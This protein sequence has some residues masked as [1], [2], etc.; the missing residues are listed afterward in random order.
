MRDGGQADALPPAPGRAGRTDDRGHQRAPFL[1]S[2]AALALK[3]PSVL[4]SSS[5][6]SSIAI[7]SALRATGLGFDTSASTLACTAGVRGGVALA[8]FS[9]LSAAWA[10][11][12]TAMSL[13]IWV[14][15]GLAGAA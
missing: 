4:S 12:M 11:R 1:R 5:L 13:R 3:S 15:A 2:R 6:A 9:T 8:S 7:R 10:S 14:A